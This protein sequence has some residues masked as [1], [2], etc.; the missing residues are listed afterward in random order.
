LLGVSDHFDL[1]DSGGVD[2]TDLAY[3]VQE[4]RG[5]SLGDANLDGVVNAT[6]L[7]ALALNWQQPS[8]LWTGGDFT[9]DGFVDS[10]DLN[11]LAVNWRNGADAA[12]PEPSSIS[13]LLAAFTIVAGCARRCPCSDGLKTGLHP[14]GAD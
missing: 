12:V 5:T 13:L 10:A 3:W 7:N 14:E 9:G 6:D 11:V 8:A 4:L 2:V 1:N